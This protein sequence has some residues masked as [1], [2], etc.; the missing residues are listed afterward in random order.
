MASTEQRFVK[1]KRNV[2]TLETKIQLLDC[3]AA[4]ETYG[5]AS[6]KFKVNES[7]VRTIKKSEQAIRAS[8]PCGASTSN[9]VTCFS[10]PQTMEKMERAL[11]IWIDRSNKKKSASKQ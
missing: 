11:G 9:K 2:M 7:T 4:G 1:R 3:L 5:S 10:R 6:K 8:V